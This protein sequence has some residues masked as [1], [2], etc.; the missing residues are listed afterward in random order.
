MI[1]H[2]LASGSSGNAL[3]VQAGSVVGL[4]DCGI[5]VRELERMLAGAGISLD[6]LSFVFVS[7][8]HSDHIRALRSLS[9]RQIPILTTEGT[10]NALDVPRSLVDTVTPNRPTEIGGVSLTPVSVH[11]DAA[12][13]CGV[14]I[15]SGGATAAIFTDLGTPCPTLVPHLEC[16]DL[17]VIEANHDE[18]MLRTGPYPA[19]LKRRVRSRVGHLSNVECATLLDTALRRAASLPVV[20]LA[21]LSET[22]NRPELARRTVAR[23]FGVAPETFVALTRRATA[24]RWAA[25]DAHPTVE[26]TRQLELMVDMTR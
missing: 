21:H 4:I 3:V 23:R 9:R 12:D 20:W 18:E 5:P 16:A 25:G 14:V 11:H 1:V 22:N 2:S 17:I 7:H 8:E 10:A 19:Y 26:V 24:Q 6:N 15:S 13:P